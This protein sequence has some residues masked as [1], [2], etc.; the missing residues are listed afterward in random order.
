M[1]KIIKN[2]TIPTLAIVIIVML[3]CST[4]PAVSTATSSQTGKQSTGQP[5]TPPAA[6][7]PVQQ[8]TTSIPGK[9][10]ATAPATVQTPPVLQSRIDVVYSHMNQRCPTCLC[11]EERINTV[12][13]TYFSEQMN[14][15]KL[16]YK[17]L[18]AQE[19]Q[20]AAFARKWGAVGSQ[21]FINTVINGFDNIEDI[22]DIWNWDCRTDQPGFDLKVKNAIEQR[23]KG[24]S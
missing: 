4:T 9:T 20:N 21:L 6:Q 7:P 8:D 3:G 12:I 14:S 10:T 15:G 22:Q 1:F 17:V 13:E 16:T 5:L 24:L 18:N 2:A 23:L 19:P 11:F